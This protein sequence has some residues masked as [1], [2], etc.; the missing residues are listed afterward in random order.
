MTLLDLIRKTR[1]QLERQG[2]HIEA[3]H[4]GKTALA[5]VNNEAA[6]EM[7]TR[8]LGIPIQRIWSLPVEEPPNHQEPTPDYCALSWKREKRS[9]AI[10]FEIIQP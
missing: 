9:P 4:L 1:R 7:G 10:L 5:Q 3:I 2:A 6:E 8:W